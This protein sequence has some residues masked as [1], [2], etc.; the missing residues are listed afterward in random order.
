MH[1]R[2]LLHDMSE[3]K[4]VL[5]DLDG[6]LLDTI[7]D[8][9]FALNQLRHEFS[10][11]PLPVASIREFV[12]EGSKV[13]LK[14]ALNIQENHPQFNALREKFLTI[15]ES[16][17]AD[18]TQFFPGMADVLSHLDEASIP[19]GIVTNKLTRHTMSLLAALELVER[20]RCVIC[21]DTLATYKPDPAPI[22]HACE[23]LNIDARDCLFVGDSIND[24][25]ASKAAGSKALVALYGYI[26]TQINPYT[27]QADGYIQ[28][29]REIITWLRK[30]GAYK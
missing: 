16:H 2:Y 8:I 26:D 18:N 13:M 1:S 10:L 17:L 7:T 25:L 3:F 20:P 15:Y 30:S 24:V 11:P 4:G 22:T 21:G 12:S 29:P 5:F 14:A 19:W 9:S 27:W 23:L 6:T 28:S